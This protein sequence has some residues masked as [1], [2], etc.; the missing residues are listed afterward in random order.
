MYK[1]DKKKI[2][3]NLKEGTPG[4]RIIEKPQSITETINFDYKEAKVENPAELQK[5]VGGKRKQKKYYDNPE[6]NWGPKPRATGK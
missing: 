1:E 6:P 5:L 2:L 4:Y 3:A